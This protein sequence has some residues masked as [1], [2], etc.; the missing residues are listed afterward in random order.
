MHLTERT[1]SYSNFLFKN[2]EACRRQTSRFV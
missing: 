1:Q 2:D